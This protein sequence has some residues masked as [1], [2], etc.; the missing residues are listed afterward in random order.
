MSARVP[1]VVVV[2]A[3]LAACEDREVALVTQE[4]GNTVVAVDPAVPGSPIGTVQL[5]SSSFDAR[6]AVAV[7][8]TA[9]RGLV[10]DGDATVEVVDVGPTGLSLGP[11][12]AMSFAPTRVATARRVAAT[13]WAVV[14]GLGTD[15][16]DAIVGKVASINVV[17]GQERDV[18]D[19]AGSVMSVDVCA[20]GSVVVV[21]T[22]PDELHAIALSSQ[23]Q[24]SSTSTTVLPGIPTAAACA[25]DSAG[26]AIG[27][28]NGDL[29]SFS[30][31][32]TP[33]LIDT[34]SSRAKDEPD[35]SERVS[36]VRMAEDG[37]AVFAHSQTI[38]SDG[39]RTSYLERVGYTASTAALAGVRDWDVEVRFADSAAGLTLF[40]SNEAGDRLFVPAIDDGELDVL[41]ATTGARIQQI[42]LMVDDLAAIDIAGPP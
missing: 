2:L 35:G 29:Q 31:G 4:N 36:T 37:T 11:P 13:P 41:D 14:T 26:G 10:P 34:V 24:L 15:A 40:A 20:D 22:S 42:D 21:T 8:G 5:A 32:G 25:P 27:Y 12:I 28:Q 17:N 9:T 16:N 18:L 7:Y 1:L 19:V 33:M 3:C 6:R 23:G 38:R 30:L 39:T